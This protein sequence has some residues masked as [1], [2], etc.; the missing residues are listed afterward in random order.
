MLS[1]N[2]ELKD[3]LMAEIIRH[4]ELDQLIQGTYGKGEGDDYQGAA[5]VLQKVVR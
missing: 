3:K 5:C 2:Q 1:F 4:R